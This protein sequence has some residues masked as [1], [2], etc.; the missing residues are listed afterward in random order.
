LC[1]FFMLATATIV[2]LSQR[3]VTNAFNTTVEIY[4]SSLRRHNFVPLCCE[5]L[6]VNY[7]HCLGGHIYRAKN[8][9]GNNRPYGFHLCPLFDRC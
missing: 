9:D 2:T 1:V 3:G 5:L 6:D 7:R 4:P 8:R